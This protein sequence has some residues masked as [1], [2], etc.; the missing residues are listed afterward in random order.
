MLSGFITNT[1]AFNAGTP[2]AATPA[3]AA[4]PS[5]GS[6]LGTVAAACGAAAPAIRAGAP[7]STQLLSPNCRFGPRA[8]KGCPAQLAAVLEAM[9][10]LATKLRAK[11]G[12]PL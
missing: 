5:L 1:S 7:E 12:P 9:R 8:T 4:A 11:F 10:V 2:L 3:G 6:P